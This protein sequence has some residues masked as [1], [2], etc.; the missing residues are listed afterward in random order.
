M[1]LP[2]TPSSSKRGRSSKIWDFFAEAGD[3]KAKCDSC[4]LEL[5]C[6]TGQTSSMRRHLEVK[7]P[8]KFLE[9]KHSEECSKKIRSNTPT[10]E[11]LSQL[12][13]GECNKL[14]LSKEKK[15]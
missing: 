1:D 3:M 10:R 11:S 12:K 8:L 2:Q 6:K 5:S 15:V 14:V 9:L 7:H 13:I 4:L